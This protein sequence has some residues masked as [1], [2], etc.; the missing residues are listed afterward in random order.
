MKIAILGGNGFIGSNL[1]IYLKNKFKNIDIISVDN[2]SGKGSKF[3]QKRLTD[4][5]IKI[6]KK[7][8]SKKNS[9][10]NVGKIDIF[11]NCCSDPTVENSKKK[12]LMLLIIIF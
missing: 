10:D 3:N 6:L 5:K 4:Y 8:L 12:I 2:N 7:N 1:S 11:I 9:L